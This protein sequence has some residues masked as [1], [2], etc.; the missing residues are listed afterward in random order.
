MTQVKEKNVLFIMYYVAYFTF[1]SAVKMSL[2]GLHWRS[3]TK[4]T[5]FGGY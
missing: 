3:K 1:V 4:F 5:G 2:F